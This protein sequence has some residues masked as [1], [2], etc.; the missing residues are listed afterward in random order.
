[1]SSALPLNSDIKDASYKK[2]RPK[3]ADNFEPDDLDQA[4]IHAG[5]DFPRYA[6]K[7]I[8]AKPRIIIAHVEGSGTE[9]ARVSGTKP[10]T[11]SRATQP[12]FIHLPIS[13][14]GN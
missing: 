1:M 7:P 13:E 11:K 9:L 4:V 5:F 14:L 3:A 6:M 2:S 10:D 8:P 12:L